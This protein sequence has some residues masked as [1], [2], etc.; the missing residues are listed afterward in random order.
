MGTSMVL[1][2][3]LRKESTANKKVSIDRSVLE[4]LLRGSDRQ[5]NMINSLLEAQSTATMGI[6]LNLQPCQIHQLIDAILLELE[7]ILQQNGVVVNNRVTDLP[8]V[9]AD[10]LQLWRVL[11]NLITNAF[12]HNPHGIELTI[13]ATTDRGFIQIYIIDNGIGIDPQ[14]QARLFELYARGDRAR[15]MPG[16]GMG[17]YLCQQIILAHGGEIGFDSH[18]DRASTF[19]FTLPVK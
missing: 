10:P 3:L 14:Q 7:P 16:L 1:Q 19:W 12:K 17:L 15:Y 18:R 4:R 9:N 2:N 8:I 5:L 6:R 13:D 11:N